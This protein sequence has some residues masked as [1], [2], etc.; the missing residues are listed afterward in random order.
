MAI[1]S[2]AAYDGQIFGNMLS[3]VPLTTDA[4]VWFERR[5]PYNGH[6]FSNLL[7]AYEELMM[8]FY[9]RRN[10]RRGLDPTSTRAI[11]KSD[12]RWRIPKMG[13]RRGSR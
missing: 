5:I 6:W 9:Y 13:Y 2:L 12:Y 1:A 10:R 3:K 8:A 7:L 4:D 11:S